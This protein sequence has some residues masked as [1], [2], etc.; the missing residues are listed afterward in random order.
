M[1]GIYIPGVEM[2]KEGEYPAMLYVFSDG[3]AYIVLQLLSYVAQTEREFIRQRQAEGIAA[4]K[5]RGVRFGQPPIVKPPEYEAVRRRYEAGE[6]TSREA[7]KL[8]N[9]AHTTFLRWVK[10]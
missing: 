4:A 6:I 7:G 9:V 5:A 8:L 2:P 1:S 10:E 3:S